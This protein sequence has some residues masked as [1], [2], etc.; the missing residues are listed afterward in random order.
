MLG[1]AERDAVLS[2]F[3]FGSD[4]PYVSKRL[5]AGPFFPET[6]DVSKQGSSFLSGLGELDDLR[7][8]A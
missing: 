6:V 5:W 2:P 4:Q 8:P 7:T 3:P 1:S